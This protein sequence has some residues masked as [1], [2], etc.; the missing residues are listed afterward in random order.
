MHLDLRIVTAADLRVVSTYSD[1]L[2]LISNLTVSGTAQNPGIVGSVSVTNGQL[3]FFGNTY[4]VNTGKINFYNANAIQP[5]LD[6]SLETLT[7]GG[8][9]HFRST[10]FG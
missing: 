4:T 1:K 5:I 7:Q 2:S 6:L 3:V 8:R 10:R 9:C